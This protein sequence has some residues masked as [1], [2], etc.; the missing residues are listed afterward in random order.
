MGRQNSQLG[1]DSRLGSKVTYD[2]SQRLD[3]VVL[4]CDALKYI[5]FKAL[6]GFVDAVVFA[7]D[8]LDLL[9]ANEDQ[10]VHLFDLLGLS[11][12]LCSVLLENL[13]VLPFDLLESRVRVVIGGGRGEVGGGHGKVGR[14]CLFTSGQ[15]RVQ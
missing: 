11:F 4:A 3:S 14:S 6:H 2:V 13:G 7:V 12:E 5:A 1:R 15:P 10:L 9:G 8:A